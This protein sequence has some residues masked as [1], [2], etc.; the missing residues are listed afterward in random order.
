MLAAKILVWGLVAGLLHTAAMVVLYGNRW[1]ARIHAAHNES[2][3]A[4]RSARSTPNRLTEQLLGTQI[5]VYVMTIGYV[6]LHPLLRS[7]GLVSAMLLALL[8]AALRVCAP[9]WALRVKHTYSN[10]YLAVEILGGVV[11]STVVALTLYVLVP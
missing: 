9:V 11:G 3:S 8:F 7:T 10:R 2:G 1:V 6:W 5:E 4:T